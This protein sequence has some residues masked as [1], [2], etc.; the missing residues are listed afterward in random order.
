MPGTL[1][2]L[3]GCWQALP[4]RGPDSLGRK[5]H[6]VPGTGALTLCRTA[7]AHGGSTLLAPHLS[8]L[9][10]HH[11]PLLIVGEKLMAAVSWTSGPWSSPLYQ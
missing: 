4:G 10:F 5:V 7:V 6:V 2:T 1:V 11:S 3:D 9:F 8:P